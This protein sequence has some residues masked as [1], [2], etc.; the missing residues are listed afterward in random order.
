MKGLQA[1]VMLALLAIGTIGLS[2]EGP[3]WTRYVGSGLLFAM[4]MIN[5]T[6][7]ANSPTTAEIKKFL[8]IAAEQGST[9]ADAVEEA[10][11]A[12]EPRGRRSVR[13]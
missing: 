6:Q 11:D 1:L 3:I 13:N 4:L 12:S 2:G 8:G 7:T 9:R 5:I 10:D